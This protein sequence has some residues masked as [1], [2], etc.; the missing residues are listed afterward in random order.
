MLLGQQ[1]AR[2]DSG[3]VGKYQLYLTQHS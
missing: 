1:D 2:S 3:M